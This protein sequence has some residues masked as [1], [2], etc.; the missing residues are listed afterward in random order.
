[1][2]FSCSNTHLVD[3]IVHKV[4]R[5]LPVDGDVDD[6]AGIDVPE[7]GQTVWVF[8]S[9]CCRGCRFWSICKEK[10]YLQNDTVNLLPTL[11]HGKKCGLRDQ[12]ASYH[13]FTDNGYRET[14][15][16]TQSHE[17]DRRAGSTQ[18][19]HTR[20]LDRSHS[21]C[22]TRSKRALRTPSRPGP[23]PAAYMACMRRERWS[24]FRPTPCVN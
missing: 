13:K 3:I 21:L 2:L 17:E 11:L 8:V 14:N 12:D 7:P 1:M 9:A 5:P 23:P 4:R 6:A 10:D 24:V 15:A 16:K 20:R 22:R 18:A 19:W